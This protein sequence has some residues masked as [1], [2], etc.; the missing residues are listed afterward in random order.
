MGRDFR[1]TPVELGVARA[2]D[3]PIPPAPRVPV[4]SSGPSRVPGSRAIWL[5]LYP[6][7]ALST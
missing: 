3:L 6:P 5:A 1:L 7:E 4:S 2:A